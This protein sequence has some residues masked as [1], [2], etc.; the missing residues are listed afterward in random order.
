M[1]WWL[2][3]IYT[4]AHWWKFYERK[5]DGYMKIIMGFAAHEGATNFGAIVEGFDEG[6][7]QTQLDLLF[8]W[9]S[10]E[11]AFGNLS[12]HKPPKDLTGPPTFALKGL[13]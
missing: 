10:C 4:V 2:P 7:N 3:R 5:L 6:S 13:G 1:L 9:D 8:A 11:T 12:G